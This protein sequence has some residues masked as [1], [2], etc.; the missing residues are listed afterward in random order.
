MAIPERYSLAGTLAP[1]VMNRHDPVARIGGHSAWW[2]ARTPDGPATLHL[3]RDGGDA[4]RHRLRS[5]RVVG[6]RPGRRGGRAA[7]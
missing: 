1:L 3:E 2:A 5:G 4:R 7:R 6:G